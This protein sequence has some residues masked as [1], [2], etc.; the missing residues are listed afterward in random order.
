MSAEAES[1]PL[2]PAFL[3]QVPHAPGVYLMENRAGQVL[4]VGKARD[5]RKR[6]AS[7]VRFLEE[8]H[9]KTGV[10]LSHAVR[11]ETII[12]NSE[13]EAFILEASLI[14]KHR[15]KYNIL[16]R[17]DKSYP[18]IK[19]TVQEEWPRLLMTRRRAKDGA[20]YFGP[21]ASAGAMWETIE[22]LNGLFPLRRCKGKE[23]RNRERPC[24][25]YQLG[26]CQ[27]P[28]AG[29]AGPERYRE[30]VAGVLL[31]LEGRNRQLVGELEAKMARAA[32]EQRYEEAALYRDRLQALRQTLEK[33]TMVAPHFR[34]QDVFGFA[35]EGAAVAVSVLF[36]RHGVVNGVSSYYL[37]EPLGGDQEVLTEVVKRFY[38]EERPVPGEVLLPFAAEDE[39]LLGEWLSEQ[40]GRRVALKVP[41]RGDRV[42]L[43][44]MA[45]SNAVQVHAD[46]DKREQAWESLAGQLQQALHLERPP[47]RIECLDIS[48]ISGE[49]AVGSLVSFRAGEK[50][51]ERYRHYKI[52]LTQGPDDYAMMREVLERRLAKGREAGDLP[53]LLLLDGGKGQLN[54]AVAVVRDLGLENGIELASI[55]KERDEGGEKLFRPGRK[56]PIL[57]ARHA[58]VLLYL[59]RIRDEAHRYGITF[60][61]RWRGKQTLASVLDEVPGIGPARKKA[62]LKS[63][64]SLKRVRA[65]S[66]EELARVAGIGPELAAQLWR[67][68]RED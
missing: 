66:V 8:R 6:L 41:Q 10:L 67:Q 29:K 16:L 56:N 26:L 25:N 42:H 14:K 52:R 27:A 23:L 68:L 49:Q 58:P 20:R 5:L 54:V 59:M 53:G 45:Q 7:Y 62:L 30:A 39:E 65:A 11:I 18:L 47:E 43:L 24:L 35:R 46:R 38:G 4:Y 61:R 13:K 12:T 57:L 28:C 21:F 36:V 15:P 51:K 2:S 60:H 37:S 32:E 3:R 63:L 22:Y 55:A 19:V 31:V 1:R 64:G 44:Q 34:D 40:S 48:N 33:Q 17:D 50:E 9:T